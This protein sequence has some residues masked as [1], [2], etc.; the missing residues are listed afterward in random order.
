MKYPAYRDIYMLVSRTSP[1]IT[2]VTPFPIEV[3]HLCYRAS[4]EI[5]KVSTNFYLLAHIAT[6]TTITDIAV[7][8]VYP[9]VVA[10]EFAV[11]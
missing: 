8:F 11:L 2:V 3:R 4:V 9:S 7:R 6:Q 1:L 10:V 5:M